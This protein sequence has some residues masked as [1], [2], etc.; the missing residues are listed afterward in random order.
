MKALSRSAFLLAGLACTVAPLAQAAGPHVH[1]IGA[2]NLAVDGTE[3]FIELHSPAADVFGFEHAPRTAE[4]REQ[5]A[6]AMDRLADGAALFRVPAEAGC[7]LREAVPVSPFAD[8]PDH[9]HDHGRHHHEDHGHEG[10]EAHTDVSA[11]YGFACAAAPAWIEVGLFETF[12]GMQRLD[13]QL[14]TVSGQGKAVLEPGASRL[15]LP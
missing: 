14:I 3:V 12:P 10:L 6:A 13:V 1:G 7:E 11:T 2:L 4:Q 8:E 9:A 5:V 15:D